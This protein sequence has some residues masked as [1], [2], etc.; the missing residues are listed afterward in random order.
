MVKKLNLLISTLY[1]ATLRPGKIPERS[2]SHSKKTN[3]LTKRTWSF[4]RNSLQ[5]GMRMVMDQWDKTNYCHTWSALELLQTWSR[6]SWF[7][8]LLER[9]ER[10][11]QWTILSGFS[12]KI[13]SQYDSWALSTISQ[14][15]ANKCLRWNKSTLVMLYLIKWI[16][17]WISQ[18]II[19]RRAMKWE[20]IWAP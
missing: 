12:G 13:K 4:L 11:S 9:R 1:H 17:F 15:D 16:S 6:L 2:K 10:K 5:L 8:R 14:F 20:I 7:S 19:R 3:V 18:S